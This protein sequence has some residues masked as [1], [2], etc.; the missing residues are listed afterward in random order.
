MT[1]AE[2]TDLVRAAGGSAHRIESIEQLFAPGGAA[3]RRGIRLE[4]ESAE[5]GRVVQ[6]GPTMRLSR[7]PMVAGALPP[8]WR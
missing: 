2:V 3:E 4:Q 8:P 7:T 6:P 5:F 1:A